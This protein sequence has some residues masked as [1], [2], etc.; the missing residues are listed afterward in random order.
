M[1]YLIVAAAIMTIAP[2]VANAQAEDM[3]PLVRSCTITAAAQKGQPR[4]VLIDTKNGDI[5]STSVQIS[6]PTKLSGMLDAITISVEPFDATI[7]VKGLAPKTEGTYVR[8]YVT[9]GWSAL[10]NRISKGNKLTL[11]TGD[12]TLTVSLAGSS[13]AVTALQHCAR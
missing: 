3:L 4:L 13:A 10:L 2:Q 6:G 8:A 11:S 9:E 12:E 5:I 7:T 1:K